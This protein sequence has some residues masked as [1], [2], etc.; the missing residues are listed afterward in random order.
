[1][2][3]KLNVYI[4]FVRINFRQTKKKAAL[5]AVRNFTFK[6]KQEKRESTFW[7]WHKCCICGQRTCPLTKKEEEEARKWPRDKRVRSVSPQ[8]YR[9]QLAFV[10]GANPPWIGTKGH[11][12]HSV[13]DLFDLSRHARLIIC[14]TLTH[15][16]DE[17][18]RTFL[19][20]QCILC[21]VHLM[22]QVTWFDAQNNIWAAVQ[23]F[24][25]AHHLLHVLCYLLVLF[26]I[27]EIG[28]LV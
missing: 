26:L 27:A 4:P 25:V 6:A 19:S 11:V 14:Y 5:I 9:T 22:L 12:N 18:V 13:T 7:P 23:K 20:T 2:L 15:A 16:H 1:M 8:S 24:R 3:Y 10:T 28:Y 21:I 17:G